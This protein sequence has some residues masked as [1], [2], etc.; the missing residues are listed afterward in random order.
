MQ[1]FDDYLVTGGFRAGK[2]FVEAGY[3]TPRDVNS[4]QS[5][6]SMATLQYRFKETGLFRY[7]GVHYDVASSDRTPDPSTKSLRLVFASH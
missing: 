3:G 4:G 7:V 2:L 6:Y 5:G 1:R